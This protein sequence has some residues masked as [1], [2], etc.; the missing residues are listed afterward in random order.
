M[1][2]ENIPSEITSIPQWVCVWKTSKIPMK[3]KEKKAASSVESSTWCDFETAVDAVEKG[4]YDNIGFVFNNNGIIGIDID[5]GFDEEGFFSE[6]SL[7]IIRACGSYTE[8]S[9]SGRGVHILLKGSLPF[10]GK[11]NLNGVEIYQS[12]RYFIVT[13]DVLVYDTIIENQKAIDYIVEKYFPNLEKENES[14]TTSTKIYAPIPQK[15]QN[16]KIPLRPQYPPIPDGSR[17]QSLASLAGQ[18]H[19]SGYAKEAIYKELLYCNS[20]ACTP[21]LPIGE[22]QNIVN[23]ITRYRR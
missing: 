6:T 9:R 19:N 23:S 10:N 16:G 7:D 4:M 5:C 8:R 20:V 13:G 18:L 17:N 21:P 14:G 15:P 3:A 22:I 12:S 11:N 2:R 1:K